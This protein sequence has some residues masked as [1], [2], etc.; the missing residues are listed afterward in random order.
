MTESRSTLTPGQWTARRATKWWRIDALGYHQPLM[1]READAR[2]ISAAP[3]M[4]H[5][6]KRM[7]RW[8]DPYALPDSERNVSDCALVDAAIAKAEGREHV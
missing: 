6:L 5:A 2:L 8:V 1:L 3:E 4:L 7:K